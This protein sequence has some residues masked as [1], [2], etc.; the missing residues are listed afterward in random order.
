MMPQFGAADVVLGSNERIAENWVSTRDG[1]Q[2]YYRPGKLYDGG[3]DFDDPHAWHFW[4]LHP[5][6]S[7]FVFADGSVR[8]LPYSIYSPTNDQLRVMA[9]RNGGEVQTGDY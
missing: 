5:G 4:S 1:P 7:N 9:T 2:S 8:F 6:G 3:D